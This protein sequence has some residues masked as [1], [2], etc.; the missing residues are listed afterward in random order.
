MKVRALEDK[1][2]EDITRSIVRQVL[3][4]YHDSLNIK[5]K[6]IFVDVH[7]GIDRGQKVAITQRV[8]LDHVI[9]RGCRHRQMIQLLQRGRR[10]IFDHA[11]IYL[12]IVAGKVPSCCIT[13][14]Y[15]L[16][17]RDYALLYI[18]RSV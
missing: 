7:G 18:H 17:I 11:T 1:L 15:K 4:L 3:I 13:A 8:R 5:W 9:S 14:L 6:C 10:I 16:K 12:D 2:R